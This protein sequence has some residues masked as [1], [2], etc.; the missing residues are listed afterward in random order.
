M[1][2]ELQAAVIGAVSGGTFYLVAMLLRTWL[3]NRSDHNV[4]R[5]ESR[6]RFLQEQISSLYGPPR[7][8]PL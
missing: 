2:I 8:L 6:V 1:G 7:R 4:T 5:H 3:S